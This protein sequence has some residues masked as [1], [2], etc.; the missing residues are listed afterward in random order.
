MLM[1]NTSLLICSVEEFSIAWLYQID[2]SNL[3]LMDIK[4]LVIFSIINSI[5]ITIRVHIF[6]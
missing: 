2:F 4:L 1:Y 5:L 3:L 6:V